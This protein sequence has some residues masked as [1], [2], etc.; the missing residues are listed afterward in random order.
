MVTTHKATRNDWA[1]PARVRSIMTTKLTTV[2]VHEDLAFAMQLMLWSN[3]RHLPVV[4]GDRLVGILSSQDF[5]PQRGGRESLDEYLRH[6]VF[7]AMKSPVKTVHPDD[8]VRDAS[9]FM[10]AER[11]HCLP[12]VEND[13]LVGIL[14][15]S[16]ILAERGSRKARQGGGHSARVTDIMTPD[17]ICCRPEQPLFD[18][19]LQM[20]REDVRHVPVVDADGAIVGIVTDRDVRVVL[21]DPVRALAD[22]DDVD[23]SD[24]SVAHA[25]TAHP[26]TV[27]P[28]T[29][30][31]E[32]AR[33]F[34]GERVGAVPVV[35]E[36]G[37]LAGIASYV[38]LLRFLIGEPPAS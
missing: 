14:T 22:S 27:A 33:V 11:I 30:I 19:V 26:V 24:L 35:D 7:H 9:G 28:T 16:D 3:I 25:M 15:A 21:G 4:E 32:L 23:F 36:N 12:V 38:D 8:D 37:R 1:A 10:V 5:L 2:G 20:V 6:P 29:S 13:E 18:I 31:D 34:I 17:P